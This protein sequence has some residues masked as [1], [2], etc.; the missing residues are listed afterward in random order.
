MLKSNLVALS[1]TSSQS[2]MGSCFRDYAWLGSPLLTN[3]GTLNLGGDTNYIYSVVTPTT[4][5]IV[6][7]PTTTYIVV[8]PTTY[9]LW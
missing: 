5:Y 4:T 6:V 3:Q 2:Y 9:I 7:T 8:T 1:P